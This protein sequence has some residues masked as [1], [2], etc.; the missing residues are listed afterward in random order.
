MESRKPIK[1]KHI[2]RISADFARH[3]CAAAP[4]TSSPEFK[5]FA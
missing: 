5:T 1:Y 2:P 3:F 4:P